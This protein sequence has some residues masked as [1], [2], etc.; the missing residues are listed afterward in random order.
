M[1]FEGSVTILGSPMV[2]RIGLEGSSMVKEVQFTLDGIQETLQCE[3]FRTHDRTRR[4]TLFHRLIRHKASGNHITSDSKEVGFDASVYDENHHLMVEGKQGLILSKLQINGALEWYGLHEYGY[5]W[6]C[7]SPT[8]ELHDPL[9]GTVELEGARATV[10]VTG[11]AGPYLYQLNGREPGGWT[12]GG[13]SYS[14]EGLTPGWHLL[15]LANTAGMHTS[16]QVQV[17]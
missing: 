7:F 5:P 6:R 13:S 14:F 2:V 17:L 1:D 9:T 12:P 8:G 15:Y 3:G 16:F 10:T 11:G 4:I